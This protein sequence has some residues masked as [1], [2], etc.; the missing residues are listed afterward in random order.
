[1]AA[2][3]AYLEGVRAEHQR[4]VDAQQEDVV[5]MAGK[6]YKSHLNSVIST[7]LVALKTKKQKLQGMLDGLLA[8]EGA[9]A[10]A[11]KEAQEEL[12]ELENGD[13]RGR[14]N[15]RL[16]E[17]CHFLQDEI[18]DLCREYTMYQLRSQGLLNDQSIGDLSRADTMSNSQHDERSEGH[19]GPEDEGFEAGMLGADGGSLGA[20]EA[21]VRQ[22]Q[23]D[24][25]LRAAKAI[26]AEIYQGHDK[27]H[28]AHMAMVV[29]RFT[30]CQ[31]L[32]NGAEQRAQL[33]T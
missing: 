12:Q 22:A 32:R 13:T 3:E 16:Q 9:E 31:E 7:D 30:R 25:A 5:P 10:D 14:K 4:C 18:E 11:Q 1:M 8:E 24:K 29:S 2:G 26:A 6:L 17:R 33:M 21:V 15:Q 27:L 19:G 23:Y 28:N 20:S